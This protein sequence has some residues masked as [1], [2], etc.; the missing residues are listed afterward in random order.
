VPSQA[1]R[2]NP[3]GLV[4]GQKYRIDYDNLVGKMKHPVNDGV[5]SGGAERVR[6]ADLLNAIQTRSQLRHSP[7]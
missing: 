5:F 4:C 6:T 1:S 3:S 7:R 2:I